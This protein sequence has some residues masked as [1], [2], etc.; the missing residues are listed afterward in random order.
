MIEKDLKLSLIS[1]DSQIGSGYVL[2]KALS[3][4]FGYAKDYLGWLSRTGRI[5]AVRHGKYGQWYASEES[6]KKYQFSLKN[7]NFKTFP[8]NKSQTS[9]LESKPKTDVHETGAQIVSAV[10]SIVLFNNDGSY[11]AESDLVLQKNNSE[12]TRIPERINAILT[13]SIV[14]GG[15]L[16]F[17]NIYPITELA[18]LKT[19]LISKFSENFKNN[20]QLAI[21]NDIGMGEKIISFFGV[22][23]VG[24]ANVTTSAFAPRDFC[25][26]DLCIDKEQLRVLLEK[27]G[28]IA[29]SKR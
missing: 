23:L 10:P 6:L 7:S 25:V 17:T 26:E 19:P 5:E 22:G 4:K 12:L 29:N 8:K 27:N 14:L 9:I 24:I 16:F 15:I 18:I 13:L 28:I 20:I 3:D 1:E 2:L 21:A 11:R